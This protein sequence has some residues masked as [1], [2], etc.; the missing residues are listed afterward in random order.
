MNAGWI[1]LLVCAGGYLVLALYG[2]YR[3]IKQDFQDA[4]D[5]QARANAQVDEPPPP[6][7][8]S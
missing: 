6:G 8:T 5:E 1:V 7:Q 3:T 4:R 2:K